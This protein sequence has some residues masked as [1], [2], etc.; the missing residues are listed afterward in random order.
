[1]LA[2]TGTSTPR[3][4]AASGP[5]GVAHVYIHP[6]LLRNFDFMAPHVHA[7]GQNRRQDEVS[8]L[9]R[10]RA[11]HRRFHPG[12]VATHLD[13][14][15]DRPLDEIQPL[16]VDVHERQ[17]RILQQGER[18][19]VAGER[20]GEAEAAGADECDLGHDDGSC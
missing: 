16:R 10:L 20:A 12:A 6:E 5:A 15:A 17:R 9:E 19:Q 14:L 1:L 11:V 13:D 7:A 3:W 18:Q 8:P 4:A 2:H